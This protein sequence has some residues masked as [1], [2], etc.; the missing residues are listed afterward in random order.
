MRARC[1][2]CVYCIHAKS[3]DKLCSLMQKPTNEDGCCYHYDEC[4]GI[5]TARIISFMVVGFVCLVLFA[6]YMHN[7]YGG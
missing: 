6:V 7:N 4:A 5:A 3:G 1:K 2:N